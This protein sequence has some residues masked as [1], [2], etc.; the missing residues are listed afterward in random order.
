MDA[1]AQAA[2]QERVRRVA[3]RLRL[4]CVYVPQAWQESAKSYVMEAIH[5]DHPLVL[6]ALDHPCASELAAWVRALQAEGVL[7]LDFEAY[8]QPDGRVAVVDVDKFGALDGRDVVLPWGERRS[9]AEMTAA[10]PA[11]WV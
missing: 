4:A 5:T 6:P 8:E 1:Y 2:L 10:M 11:S 9:A 7:P 3:V